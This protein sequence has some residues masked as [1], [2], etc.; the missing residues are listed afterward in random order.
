[1]KF[2]NILRQS[3]QQKL[4]ICIFWKK[5]NFAV[6]RFESD[7]DDMLNHS[8]VIKKKFQKANH[9]EKDNDLDYD[10]AALVNSCSQNFKEMINPLQ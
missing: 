3:L 7:D 5:I 8:F 10:L 4:F 2:D 6:T 1:M 9:K